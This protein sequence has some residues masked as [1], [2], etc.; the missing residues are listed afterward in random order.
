[1][2]IWIP[3]LIFSSNAMQVAWRLFYVLFVPI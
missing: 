2:V 1:M 3:L